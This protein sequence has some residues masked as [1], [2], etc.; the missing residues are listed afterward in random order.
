M[1]FQGWPTS[2]GLRAKFFTVVL[3]RATL[4]THTHTHPLSPSY[5][6]TH[7]HAQNEILTIYHVTNVTHPSLWK[8]RLTKMGLN[9]SQDY[10]PDFF[11]NQI[12]ITLQFLT[13][14]TSG[15]FT[16]KGPR[17]YGF[18]FSRVYSMLGWG[19]RLM[20]CGGGG[21]GV[22]GWWGGGRDWDSGWGNHLSASQEPHGSCVR[23]KKE[24]RTMEKRVLGWEGCDNIVSEGVNGKGVFKLGP[25]LFNALIKIN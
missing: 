11:L 9:S 15:Q 2:Q 21:W 12:H 4:C 3:Q 8:G 24:E 25:G 18:E 22:K 17:L 6:N 10:R 23:M 5:T 20:R 19:A 13:T 14:K 1:I 16:N 7:I